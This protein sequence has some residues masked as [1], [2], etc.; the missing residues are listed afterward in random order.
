MA[1]G[2]KEEAEADKRLSSTAPSTVASKSS[3]G[4]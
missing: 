4:T 1:T 2:N 3:A